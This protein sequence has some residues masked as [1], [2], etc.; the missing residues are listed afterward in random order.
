M[1]QLFTLATALVLLLGTAV[2]TFAADIVVKTVRIKKRNVSRS[3]NPSEKYINRPWLDC[4]VMTITTGVDEK[5][6]QTT[7]KFATTFDLMKDN[8]MSVATMEIT[9]VDCDLKATTKTLT[10]VANKEGV[11]E[12]GIS[13]PSTKG[14]SLILTSAEIDATNANSEIA[15]FEAEL[16]NPAGKGK[17][18]TGN[19][20]LKE[21]N[22]LTDNASGFYVMSFSMAFE[23]ELPAATTMLVQV[24]NCKGVNAIV[25]VKLAYDATTGVAI[26]STGIAQNKDC[27]WVLTYGEVYSIDACG[28]ESAWA[29]DFSQVKTN[30]TGTRS[31][32]GALKTKPKLK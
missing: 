31:G 13:L 30:G 21:V 14:C 3:E 29:V 2:P 1:K 22:V 4:N 8:T 19:A 6:G 7:F 23:K 25:A 27:P 5:S 10:L 11:Y 24:T 17:D 26:G 28:T 15:A 12:A 16:D 9:V 20:K 18:C 32:A